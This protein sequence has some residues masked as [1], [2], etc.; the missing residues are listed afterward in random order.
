[1]GNFLTLNLWFGMYAGPLTPLFRN[2]L[3]GIIVAFLLLLAFSTIRYRANKKNLYRKVWGSLY[4]FSVTGFILG[5][6]LLFFTSQRI[7][8]FSM[9]IWFV[10]WALIH[11]AWGYF[12]YQTY[13]QVPEVEKEL[14][15]KREFKK[16]TP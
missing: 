5:V 16:Y 9:R 11:I 15:K 8:F 10:V 4:S 13:R 6:A 1:M 2:V 7:P 14:Q 3:V 12:I